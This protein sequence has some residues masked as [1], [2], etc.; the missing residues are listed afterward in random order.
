MNKLDLKTKIF[1]F[2]TGAKIKKYSHDNQKDIEINKIEI[3][4][5]YIFDNFEEYRNYF[6]NYLDCVY[7]DVIKLA[8][9]K[10]GEKDQIIAFKG[11]CEQIIIK[12]KSKEFYA[13]Y[14]NAKINEIHAKGKITPKEIIEDYENNNICAPSIDNK[15]INHRCEFFDNCHECLLEYATHQEEYNQ[16]NFQDIDLKDI[17]TLK[18]TP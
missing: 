13:K 12:Q 4:D 9:Y 16:V 1:L 17:K 15:S 11:L 18:R 7:D 14:N 6:K 10:K 2:A 8:I 5:V 3:N